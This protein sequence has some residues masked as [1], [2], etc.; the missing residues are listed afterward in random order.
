MNFGRQ[1]SSAIDTGDITIFGHSTK[2]YSG[3]EKAFAYPYPDL[4]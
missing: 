3:Y 2:N 4:G 1:P